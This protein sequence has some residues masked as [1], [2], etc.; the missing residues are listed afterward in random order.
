MFCHAPEVQQGHPFRVT[1][2]NE[3]IFGADCEADFRRIDPEK[4][5][6]KVQRSVQT[7]G[8]SIVHLLRGGAVRRPSQAEFEVALFNAVR[9][10][11]LGG[12]P[13]HGV[14]AGG[15]A[16]V[17]GEARYARCGGL[18]GRTS[19]PQSFWIATQ[20]RPRA[21]RD[22]KACLGSLLDL[23]GSHEGKSR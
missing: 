10:K 17:S 23:L 9:L 7:D 3:R 16:G 8:V 11:S 12:F 14:P 2:R 4:A 20:R 19:R 5:A 21:S 6:R 22:S 18:R 1:D 13:S 15:G